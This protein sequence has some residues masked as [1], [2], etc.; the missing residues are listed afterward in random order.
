MKRGGGESRSQNTFV[1]AV[2]WHVAPCVF[3]IKR[4]SGGTCRLHLQGRRNGAS[5]ETVRRTFTPSC[6]FFYP[7]GDTFLRNVGL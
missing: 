2:F 7:G 6:Y 1:I 4:R 3:I 5:E